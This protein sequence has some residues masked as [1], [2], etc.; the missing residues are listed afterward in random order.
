MVTIVQDTFLKNILRAK[1][2]DQNN[3]QVYLSASMSSFHSAFFMWVN[4]A[5]LLQGELTA[6]AD[7]VDSL[8]RISLALFKRFM[9]LF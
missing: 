6:S 1:N 8:Y 2:K 9:Y 4:G 7:Q 3:K 5:I